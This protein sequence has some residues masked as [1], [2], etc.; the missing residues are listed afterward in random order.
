MPRKKKVDAV[1]V[2]P[3]SSGVFDKDEFMRFCE[4]LKVETKEMGIVSLGSTLLG[5]QT[6]F[7]DEIAD[8][9]ANGIHY[10]IVLKGRQ[11]GIT[12][13]CLALDLYW[14][15]KHAGTQGTLATDTEENREMFR[16]TLTMYMD[17][18]PMKWRQPVTQH[19]RTQVVLQN[20]SRMVYQVAGT[21]KNVG[22][23]AGKA[24]S[25]MHATET[26]KWGE[27]TDL[28]S[29]EAS[30]AQS[31]P[32]RLF[33][34]ES[35][36]YGFNAF[37]EMW[38]TALTA[39][40]QKAIFIGWWRNDMYRVKKDD[41]DNVRREIYQVYWD[42]KLTTGEQKWVD[43]VKELYDFDIDDEQIA[44]WRWT[45]NEM[46][47]GEEDQMFEKYPPTADY[48]FIM[49]GSQF[50]SQ[51]RLTDCM[52][53]AKKKPYISK[54]FVFG[55]SFED[56]E[57]F[58]SNERTSNLK[59]WEEP[60]AKGQYVMGCD[61]AWG[62]SEWADRFAINVSRVWSDG[63]EQVAEFCTTDMNTMQYAWTML[64]LAGAY[65]DQGMGCNVMINLELNGP[66][67]A[68]WNEMQSMRTRAAMTGGNSNVARIL[69][70]MQNY[71]YRRP[72]SIG[73]GFAYH[74]K[75]TA[76][77]KERMMNLMKDNHEMG[78]LVI[79]SMDLLDEMKNVIRDEGTIGAPG[80]GKDD[81][82]IAQALS[83]LP[84]NDHIRIRLIQARITRE[85]QRKE[86]EMPESYQKAGRSIATWLKN[87]GIRQPPARVGH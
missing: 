57:I 60:V 8:G 18:L 66:G 34:F 67:V 70:N 38:E 84:W 87:A 82:V 42:G 81:R 16:S 77:E 32:K 45:L 75:S 61:P 44:W 35:T 43:E 64:Y 37:N 2:A 9:L 52:K 11:L 14:H 86:A 74:T 76:Q 47:K 48:A 55:A 49:S 25:F 17:S 20:R 33:V 80:R 5:S 24:I 26:G 39:S 59:I 71:L 29:L 54:R 69:L 6:Y 63:M 78:F 23:G 51:Q 12:T 65:G 22:F 30:L 41:P 10:F 62:S 72:D 68:V 40:T 19:N 1:A 50:F 3:V 58:D 36:A 83:M 4:A 46:M 73:G 15:F 28:S 13:I 27:G 56:T 85:S 21:R 31:N 7:I 79:N 53:I